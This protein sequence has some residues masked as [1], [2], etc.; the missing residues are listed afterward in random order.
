MEVQATMPSLTLQN[1]RQ[2]GGDNAKHRARL[3]DGETDRK[4][5]REREREREKWRNKGMKGDETKIVCGHIL[6]FFLAFM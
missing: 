4:G 3:E 6:F 1:H 2:T 5:G